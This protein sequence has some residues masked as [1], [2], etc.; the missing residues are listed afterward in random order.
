MIG[1]SFVGGGTMQIKYRVWDGN[2]MW[3]PRDDEFY[4]DQ[5]G[6]VKR[7]DWGERTFWGGLYEAMLY[8][9]DDKGGKP[10]YVDDIVSVEHA[11]GEVVKCHVFWCRN[12]VAV[13]LKELDG[14]DPLTELGP[15]CD[16]ASYTV[17]GNKYENPDLL[18]GKVV[19]DD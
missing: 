2:K 1:A 10:I 18:T 7:F 5:T 13:S 4:L 9:A 15:W 16:G 6:E 19:A 8:V 12:M 3:Y 14:W 17:L 11:D